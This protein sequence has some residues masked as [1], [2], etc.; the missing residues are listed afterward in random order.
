MSVTTVS[1]MTRSDSMKSRIKAY[2]R[3]GDGQFDSGE[4]VGMGVGIDRAE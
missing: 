1:S 4:V 3:N 2:D